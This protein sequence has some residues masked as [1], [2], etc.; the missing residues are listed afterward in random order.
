MFGYLRPDKPYLYMKDDVLYRALYCGVCKSIG[1]NVGQIARFTLTYDIAFMNA[2]CHNILGKDVKINKEHCITHVIRKTPVAK[3][4]DISLMLADVNVIL[5]YYKL[6]DDV[7][8]E[9]KGN[10]KSAVFKRAYKKASARLKELDGYI[11]AQTKI[12]H[13]LEKQ[14][15]DS[16]DM[17]ADTSA[18]ILKEIART[19]LKEKSTEYTD[20]FFYALGK[21]IYLIDAIDDYD[22]DVKKG[23]FNVFY[24][25][26]KKANFEELMLKNYS[27]ITFIFNGVFLQIAENF[28]NIKT[29]Y[30]TDLIQNI[31]TRGIPNTT[32]Q[33]LTKNLKGKNNAK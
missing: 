1:K 21:W 30:N 27:E 31:V 19:V 12:L 14:G 5:A 16:I 17:V 9:K 4:D 23:S 13:D 32:T 26:Y 7:L 20:G 6:I 10:L 28:K 18:N 3:P 25:A 11:L 22:K 15:S 8:D 24:N 33:I 29:Q 2:I